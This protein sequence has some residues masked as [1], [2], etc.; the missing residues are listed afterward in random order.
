MQRLKKPQQ[1]SL[2]LG[3]IDKV[4]VLGLETSMIFS[5]VILEATVRGLTA[6]S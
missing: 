5:D 4:S 3:S 6:S 1:N 2:A